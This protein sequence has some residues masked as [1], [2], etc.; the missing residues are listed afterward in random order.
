MQISV[1]AVEHYFEDAT[2]LRDWVL[3]QFRLGN[4]I[5]PQM[6][7]HQ[8][9]E[10]TKLGPGKT[11]QETFRTLSSLLLDRGAHMAEAVSKMTH[12]QVYGQ[13]L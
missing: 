5:V 4:H 9:Q 7:D 11:Q 8:A 2:R 12:G 3:E 13:L 10:W 6:M 1:V